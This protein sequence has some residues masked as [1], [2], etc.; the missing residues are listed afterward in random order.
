M[1]V[2]QKRLHC[3]FRSSSPN[4]SVKSLAN[5]P[6]ILSPH[7]LKIGSNQIIWKKVNIMKLWRIH[8]YDRSHVLYVRILRD[9]LNSQE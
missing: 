5:V 9:V 8:Y 2:G 4:C 7:P 6:Y 1:S 3:N